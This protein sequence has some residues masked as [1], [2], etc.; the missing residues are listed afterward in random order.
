[1]GPLSKSPWVPSAPIVSP[2]PSGTSGRSC[3]CLSPFPCLFPHCLKPEQMQHSES[4]TAT[5]NV[6]QCWRM[7]PNLLAEWWEGGRPGRGMHQRTFACVSVDSHCFPSFAEHSTA[8][9]TE[10]RLPPVSE[11]PQSIPVPCS[12]RAW[13]HLCSGFVQ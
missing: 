6:E 9:P 1:M 8:I 12:P 4:I 5:P 2:V 13:G 11:I 10:H 7:V 3:S